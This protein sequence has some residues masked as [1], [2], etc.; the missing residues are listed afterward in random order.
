MR[1]LLSLRRDE[2]PIVGEVYQYGAYYVK[3]VS[4][5]AGEKCEKCVFNRNFCPFHCIQNPSEV[6]KHFEWVP[7]DKLAT[8]ADVK[9]RHIEETNRTSPHLGER[10]IATVGLVE[11][12]KNSMPDLDDCTF[13]ELTQRECDN[14][15]CGVRCY[16]KKVER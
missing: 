11:Y 10:L 6:E 12:V 14:V 9:F 1:E 3:C 2:E 16:Y 8:A 5:G 7:G 4:G 15:A 13:C